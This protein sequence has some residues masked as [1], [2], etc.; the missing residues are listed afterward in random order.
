MSKRKIGWMEKGKLN[1]SKLSERSRQQ[2]GI[3][4]PNSFIYKNKS[5]GF[6]DQIELSDHLISFYILMR[7]ITKNIF[8][9]TIIVL[10]IPGFEKG[11]FTIYP[12][13]PMVLQVTNAL[14]THIFNS[15]SS[16]YSIEIFIG[17]PLTPISLY[18]NMTVF[19]GILLALP[20]TVRQIMKFITPGLKE[21]E[22]NNLK[23][24]AK[25]SLLLFLIGVI[26]SYVFILPNTLRILAGSGAIIGNASLLQMYSLQSV[27]NLMMW[28]TLGGGLLYASP[29][30]LVALVN[31]EVIQAQSIDERRKEIMMAIFVLAAFITPDPTIVSMLVL[32]LPMIIIVEFIITWSYKIELRKLTEGELII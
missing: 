29:L 18:L 7:K 20:M 25:S 21:K 28:G 15:F 1:R 10:I 8:I 13:K 16:N 32:S 19:L 14:I 30:I 12:F 5:I 2:L 4:N 27:I 6:G 31:L 17:S 3:N 24:I 11:N 23:I 26:V 22:I 9:S